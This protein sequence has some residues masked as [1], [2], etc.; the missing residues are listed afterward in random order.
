MMNITIRKIEAETKTSCI[1]TVDLDGREFNI[2]YDKRNDKIEINGL[3]N[4]D[5]AQENK[6]KEECKRQLDEYNKKKLMNAKT[7][8]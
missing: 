3:P 6:I 1:F 2:T 8:N 5:S 4:L 7:K